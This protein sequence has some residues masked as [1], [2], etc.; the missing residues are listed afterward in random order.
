MIR[1][2]WLCCSRLTVLLVLDRCIAF[3]R[4]MTTDMIW[5]A[6]LFDWCVTWH[7]QYDV[8]KLACIVL[9]IYMHVW[10]LKVILYCM[11]VWGLKMNVYCIGDF[12][13][14]TRRLL[15]RDWLETDVVRTKYLNT[16]SV[17]YSYSREHT[18]LVIGTKYLLDIQNWCDILVDSVEKNWWPDIS[19]TP[20]D[21]YRQTLCPNC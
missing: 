21:L 20:D 10:G 11:H 8:W 7:W 15:I 3:Q 19:W 14:C 9:T 18:R 4:P 16:S 2:I 17:L 1:I 13:M 12:H 6:Y 5:V